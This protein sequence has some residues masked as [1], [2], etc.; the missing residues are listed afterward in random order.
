MRSALLLAFV[1]VAA[2]PVGVLAA[3][4]APLADAGLDQR[5]AVDRTVHL[6]A[7]GSGD[8]DGALTDYRW[9]VRSPEGAA[10][11]VGCDSCARTSFVPRRHGHYIATLTVTGADGQHASDHLYVHVGV[12]AVVGTKAGTPA[13]AVT[14]P[15][16]VDA[17]TTAR[18]WATAAAGGSSL[19]RIVWRVDGRVV[20][21]L[22]VDGRTATVAYTHVFA[23]ASRHTVNATVV[24]AANAT[25][26]NG[27]TVTVDSTF[28]GGSNTASGDTRAW[29]GTWDP[30]LR[31][32]GPQTLTGNAPARGT[33][34]VDHP[35]Q[36][37]VTWL[38]DGVPVGE[39]PSVDL[40][41]DTG[42]HD[43]YVAWRTPTQEHYGAFAGNETRV[44]VDSGPEL[45]IAALDGGDA[46]RVNATA[47]DV[48][49]DLTGVVLAV[50][51]VIVALGDGD[52]TE[53]RLAERLL[54][55]AGKHTVV[56]RAT[57]AHGQAARVTR[58]VTITADCGTAENPFPW[59]PRLP[60]CPIA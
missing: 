11:A 5:A 15:E 51:G 29:S 60:T 32:V 8:P 34:V 14:G 13:L 40:S 43:L 33:Y 42:A 23:D 28:G 39:G 4:G 22:P 49:A 59:L 10:V 24:D 27:T 36:P 21:T 7:T 2:V 3:D 53:R 56:V 47:R 18:Y 1:L 50:D 44:V 17:G 58:D 38:L 31:V 46:L 26:T 45:D 16:R 54:L 9:R 41:L 12:P 30:D 35:V 48:G 6:D 19:Q 57:D 20:R 55:P 25:A 52:G 37:S